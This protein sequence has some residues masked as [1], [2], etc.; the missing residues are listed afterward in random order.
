VVGL[1]TRAFAHW[2]I[3]SHGWQVAAGSYTVSVGTSS[4]DLP[5]RAPVQ[6]TTGLSGA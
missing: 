4:R 2:D 1:P 5:L 3:L 6:V